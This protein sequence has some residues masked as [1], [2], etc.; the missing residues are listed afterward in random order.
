[1]KVNIME[2]EIAVHPEATFSPLLGKVDM[3]ITCFC[4]EK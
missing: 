4:K 1:M 2:Y 3:G